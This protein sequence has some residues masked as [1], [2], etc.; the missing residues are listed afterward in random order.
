MFFLNF[1][2]VFIVMLIR[3]VF[4]MLPWCE[5]KIINS[6]KENL[7]WIKAYL[8]R[9]PWEQLNKEHQQL[10]SSAAV[11]RPMSVVVHAVSHQLRFRTP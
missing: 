7:V 8:K 11:T 2:L 10:L 4:C 9:W 1:F 3:H 5:I 6:F